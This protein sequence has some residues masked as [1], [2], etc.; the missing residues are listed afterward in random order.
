MQRFARG[1]RE[2]WALVSTA[3][4][5]ACLLVFL[6]FHLEPDNR[7]THPYASSAKELRELGLSQCEEGHYQPCVRFLDEAKARD[8]E[9]EKDPAVV[10]A[11]S[12]A[13]KALRAK[14]TQKP[15]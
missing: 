8:P 14:D 15:E 12:A 4:A 1:V 13:E 7:V 10:A 11:R 2:R 6:L 3:A 9:G 5:V